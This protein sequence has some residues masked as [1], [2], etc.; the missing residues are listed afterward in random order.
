MSLSC[1]EK[2]VLNTS[3]ACIAHPRSLCQPVSLEIV[4]P[5]DLGEQLSYPKTQ[6]PLSD[7]IVRVMYTD[8]VWH[9]GRML[10][11]PPPGRKLCVFS[12][13]RDSIS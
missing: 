12:S 4:D 11:N 2:L 8:I 7:F 9:D 6:P 5:S 1:S 10:R 3:R 13:L